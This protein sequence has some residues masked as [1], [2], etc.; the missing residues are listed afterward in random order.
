[1]ETGRTND[2]AKGFKMGIGFILAGVVAAAVLCVV[3]V[4]VLYGLFVLSGYLEPSNPGVC[5]PEHSWQQYL[6]RCRDE[7]VEGFEGIPEQFYEALHNYG[8]Q[9]FGV[10]VLGYTGGEY[11]IHLYRLDAASNTWIDSPRATPPDAP[12][13]MWDDVDASATSTQWNVPEAVIEH[14]CAEA[15]N[16]MHSRQQ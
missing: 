5:S 6:A 15:D 2:V 9:S 14:W 7:G 13:G 10:L 16:F 12:D 3:A 11:W 8:D 4:A 1:M